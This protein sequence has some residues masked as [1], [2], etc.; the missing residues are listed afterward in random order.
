MTTPRPTWRGL[1]LLAASLLVTAAV[2]GGQEVAIGLV[3]L[4]AVAALALG[5]QPTRP[6]WVLLAITAALAGIARTTGS[7]WVVALMVGI[8]ATLA[9]ATSLPLVSGRRLVVRLEAPADATATRPLHL[10]A[11]ASG[12]ARGVRLRVHGVDAGEVVLDAPSSGTLEVVPQRRGVLDGLVVELVAAAPLGLVLRRR[13]RR[14]PL[15]PPVAVGPLPLD[16]TLSV[17]SLPGGAADD[18]VAVAGDDPELTRS[19]REYVVGD[20]LRLVHWP[21]TARTGSLMVRELEAPATQRLVV[22]VDLR[23]GDGD[24]VEAAAS[25]AAG[26]ALAALRSG[27][28]LVLCTAEAAPGAAGGT[29]AVTRAV[30]STVEVGR[31]LARAVPGP[32]GEA[33]SGREVAVVRVGASG[34]D[35]AGEP[36][37]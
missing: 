1:V 4:A 9:A 22:V 37:R 28:P 31:R 27:V 5:L 8:G 14:C 2:T 7:G 12:R 3:L 23:D 24:A 26:L 35:A 20:P 36:V 10:R 17:P 29:V 11:T 32:P 30:G 13:W 16:T 21:A 34:A 6:A 19:A 15:Q 25:R 33:P 18:G